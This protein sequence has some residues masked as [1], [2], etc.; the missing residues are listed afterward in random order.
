MPKAHT[1]T[2]LQEAAVTCSAADL[3][4]LIAAV[5]A[6]E[7]AI[8]LLSALEFSMHGYCPICDGWDA[9]P[10]GATKGEHS[11]HGC[12]L[13]AAIDAAIAKEKP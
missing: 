5:E 13:R 2:E 11:P 6:G 7:K 12:E 4:T 3:R 9:S 8:V 1:R 10:N